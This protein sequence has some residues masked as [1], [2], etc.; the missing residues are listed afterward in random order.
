MD[1]DNWGKLIDRHSPIPLH[2]QLSDI[3]AKSIEEG[4]FKPGNHL[5]S[6]NDLMNIFGVSRY[7]VRQT[8]NNLGRQGLIYTE[9]GRG[10]F[11]SGYQIEKPLDVLQSYHESMRKSGLSVEVRLLTKS[12]MLPPGHIANQLGL[13][14]NEQAFYLERVAYIGDSPLNILIS[15]IPLSR[16]DTANLMQFSD[17]SFYEFL[18][19]EFKIKLKRSRSYIEVVF[20]GEYESRLLNLSRGSVLLQITGVVYDDVDQPVEYSRVVYPATKFRFRFDSF[21]SDRANDPRRYVLP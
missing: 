19:R 3:L 14:T 10:S 9:H 11:V 8:L 2:Q 18:T 17:G 16:L 4:S 13:S 12:V 1:F 5:P 21:M 6:E 7:V 20:A 15:Y